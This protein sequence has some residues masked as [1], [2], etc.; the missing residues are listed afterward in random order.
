MQIW[1]DDIFSK[2]RVLQGLR[3]QPELGSQ[4]SAGAPLGSAGAPRGS[5][6]APRVS[7]FSRSYSGF[8]QSAS[9]LR[10]QP[11]LGSQGSWAR[12]GDSSPEGGTTS[13]GDFFT[14]SV[15]DSKGND[16]SLFN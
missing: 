10:V 9:G 14:D 12:F 1:Q 3:V 4:G 13:E 6:G 7:G 15:N 11:E 16:L 2:Q 5:A 8:C